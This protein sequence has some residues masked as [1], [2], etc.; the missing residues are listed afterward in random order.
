MHTVSN[1]ASSPMFSNLKHIAFFLKQFYITL[2]GLLNRENHWTLA[3]G[4]QL[5]WFIFTFPA[6]VVSLESLVVAVMGVVLPGVALH[7]LNGAIIAVGGVEIVI[8]GDVVDP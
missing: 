8:G 1:Y 2:V 5:Q 4:H 3:L 7:R 6:S